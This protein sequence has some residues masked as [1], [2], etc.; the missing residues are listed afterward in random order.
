[1]NYVALGPVRMRVTPHVEKLLP[2]V[3]ELRVMESIAPELLTIADNVREEYKDLPE[4]IIRR[5]VRDALDAAKA[6]PG[7]LTIAG[8]QAIEDELIRLNSYSST[9]LN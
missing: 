9:G 1:M 7:K 8:L 3:V 2:V 6:R 5:K 4:H